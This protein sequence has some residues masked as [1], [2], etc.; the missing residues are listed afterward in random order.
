M[1]KLSPREVLIGR[2]EKVP[3]PLVMH[4]PRRLQEDLV[5]GVKNSVSSHFHTMV[6]PSSY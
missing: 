5:A 4:R 2:M 1:S 3:D 6:N